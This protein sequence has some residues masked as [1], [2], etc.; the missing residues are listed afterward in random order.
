MNAPIRT[1]IDPLLKAS[2]IARALNISKSQ[3]YRLMRTCLP[4]VKV[5]SGVIRVRLS[6]L[7]GF[8]NTHREEHD[9]PE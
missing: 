6:D 8:I 5:S 4:V 7:E 3:T 2:D 1:Q 9:Q